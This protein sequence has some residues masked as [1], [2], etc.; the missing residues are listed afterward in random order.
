MR[1]EKKVRVDA[2][3]GD[4]VLSEDGKRL[5]VSHFDLQRA[6][7]N[8]GDLAAARSTLAVIDPDTM[9][10]SGSPAP[11]RIPLCIAAHGVVLSRPDGARAA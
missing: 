5:V 2:N 8:P 1:A 3:P 7:E 9:A 6:I 4:I 10:L 11:T